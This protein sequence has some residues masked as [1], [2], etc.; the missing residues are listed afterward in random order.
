VQL[1]RDEKPEFNGKIV[2]GSK[3]VDTLLLTPTAVTKDNI[4]V[5]VTDGFYTKEQIE[6]K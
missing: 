2:N 6:G 5:Y 1:V 4:D 3:E